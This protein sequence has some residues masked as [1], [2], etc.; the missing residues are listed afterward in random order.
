MNI[1]NMDESSACNNERL[2]ITQ[3][4]YLAQSDQT[5]SS[6]PFMKSFKFDSNKHDPKCINT[7]KLL[8]SS[9]DF[10]LASARLARKQTNYNLA[11]R[12]ITQQLAHIQSKS[13]NSTNISYE[14]IKQLLNDLLLVKTQSNRIL[15]LECELETAKLLYSLSNKQSNQSDCVLLLINSILR[16]SASHEDSHP[17]KA[18]S[19]PILQLF[20]N[21]IQSSNLA[22]NSNDL[23]NEMCS[24]S[25]LTLFKWLKRADTLLK[26]I[27]S[28][29]TRTYSS[30]G[31]TL[32]ESLTSNLTKI[33]ELK[34]KYS[35]N[36]NS[37]DFLK[38]NSSDLKVNLNGNE[39][40]LGDLL[41]LA[42]MVSPKQAKTWYTMANWCYKWG[43]RM[44]DKIQLNKSNSQ[45]INDDEKTILLELLPMHTS[46]EEK[47]FIV[48]LFL[49]GGYNKLLNKSAEFELCLQQQQ[50]QQQQSDSN[51]KFTNELR[52]VLTE[53]CK[54]L[55]Y[56]CIENLIDTWKQLTNRVFYFNRIAC[57]A[58]FTYLNLSAQVII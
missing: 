7:F 58:Y 55:S 13:F 9:D 18:V 54:S 2:M 27:N 50:Q 37:N 6:V 30:S 1:L 3:L 41:D 48:Y 20:I 19:N 21:P 14:S 42:T 29:L 57:K 40:I 47:E 12:L 8:P 11:S 52:C 24:K 25:I 34:K 39:M 35:T 36:E 53:N 51:D 10:R 32:V 28:H 5:S 15:L 26:E 44:S 49:R 45:A 16:Y 46:N 43:K 33:V 56:D 4:A 38:F 22:N 23:I 31:E 17:A